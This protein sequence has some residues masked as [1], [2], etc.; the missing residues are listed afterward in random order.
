M[1]PHSLSGGAAWVVQ[2]QVIDQ[3]FKLIGQ[4]VFHV[5]VQY[6]IGLH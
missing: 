3:L 1:A 6:E 4:T 5:Y 2:V